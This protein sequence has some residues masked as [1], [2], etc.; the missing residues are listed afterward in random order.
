MGQKNRPD[1]WFLV[2]AVNLAAGGRAGTDRFSPA[3]DLYVCEAVG[4]GVP[5]PV[6]RVWVRAAG[7][8]RLK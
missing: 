1:A 3:A 5:G 2:S 4:L 6:R 8:L 7:V